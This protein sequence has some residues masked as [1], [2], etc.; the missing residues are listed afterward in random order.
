[1]ETEDHFPAHKIFSF[2]PIICLLNVTLCFSVMV[3]YP[4][5]QPPE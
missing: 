1:M 5:A 2:D 4:Y 3:D